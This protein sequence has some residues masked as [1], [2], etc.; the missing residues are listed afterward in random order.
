V[1]DGNDDDDVISGLC[2]PLKDF[3]LIGTFDATRAA[4][5]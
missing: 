3:K 2:E 1:A 5:V 4:D